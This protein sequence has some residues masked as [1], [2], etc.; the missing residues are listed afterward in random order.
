MKV[1]DL[2][3][4]KDA[5]EEVYTDGINAIQYVDVDEKDN[6]VGTFRDGKKLYDFILNP[7]AA[8]PGDQVSYTLQNPDVINK[9]DADID[10]KWEMKNDAY[11]FVFPKYWRMDKAKNCT[12][13][14]ACGGSCIPA[15]KTCRAKEGLS[16][17]S[18]EKLKK[19]RE[20]VKKS[21]KVGDL[22]KKDLEKSL[23]DHFE[24]GSMKELK[25]DP[26]FRMATSA[27]R[28]NGN[29]LKRTN[30]LA[31]IYRKNVGIIP[32]DPVNKPGVRGVV[33]GINIF[34]YPMPWDAFGI[35]N[36]QTATTA[37]I[38]KAYREVAKKYHPDNK[39]TGDAEVFQRL[40]VFYQSLTEDFS[41]PSKK[42][43]S[44]G[45]RK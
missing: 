45:R 37:D 39:E 20:S 17:G 9:N 7:D 23:M 25:D 38:K 13:G 8:S 12:K 4:I 10:W 24:V 14:T 43:S 22:T 41:E 32:N 36:P 6:I 21:A 30:V 29:D 42:K 35:K 18:K 26:R 40:N 31:K 11:V 33:N 1:S 16:E 3:A 15:T 28:V 2:T 19:T 34:E 5:L 44:K 27:D